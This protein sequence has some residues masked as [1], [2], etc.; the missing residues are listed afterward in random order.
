MRARSL[1]LCVVVPFF[2]CSDSGSPATG[3]DDE[4]AAAAQGSD[5]V[6]V[7]DDEAQTLALAL[8][9]A[10]ATSGP[11]I[12][13][14]Q[15][16]SLGARLQPAGC[17][18][19]TVSGATVTYS[20]NE[21]TGPHGMVHLT[22]TLDVTYS[23]SAAGVHAHIAATD[24]H[25]NQSTLT[26]VADA[27]YLDTG[28]EKTLTVSTDGS[29]TGPLGHSFSHQG[30]YT[31][32]WTGTCHTLSGSWSTTADRFS[33]ST[34]VSDLSR[35]EG[36]CPSGSFSHTFRGGTTLTLSFAGATLDWSLGAKSG[37]VALTCTPQS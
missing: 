37:S 7:T 32:T 6:D 27:T 5:S 9:G 22:G 16:A 8:E 2:G 28:S 4:P 14:A 19:A 33:R 34:T 23:Y 11:Q 18:S 20:F 24:F 1:L 10:P 36:F 3:T 31:I 21:C 15:A 26:I 17:F 29:G 12:A 35:C 13:S 30:S 25:V